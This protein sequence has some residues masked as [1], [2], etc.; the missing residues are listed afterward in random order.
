MF[1]A[2]SSFGQV[3][4]VNEFLNIGVGA[5]AHGMAGSVVA[6]VNDGTAGYWNT[7]ALTDINQPFQL[8]AMHAEWFGGISNYDFFSITKRLNK[9]RHTYGGL[10]FIRLGVD[11]IPNTL[12]LFSADG[13]IDY[14]KITNFSAS[15]YAFLLSYA[16]SLDDDNTF[17]VG[18]NVK[19]IRRVL[20]PFAGAWGFGADLSMK[21]KI[22]QN[23]TV[24]ATARDIT[25]TFNA[26][27][28]NLDEESKEIFRNTNNQ[29]PESSVE[30]TLPRLILGSAYKNSY[31]DFTY[32]VEVDATLSTDGR[33][34]G[35]ISSDKFDFEPSLGIEIGYVNKVF[36]RAGIGNIQKALDQVNPELTK[37]EFQPNIGLG[38]KLGR[39]SVDYALANVGNVSGVLASHIFSVK[40]SF[41]E[42][43][44]PK[45]IE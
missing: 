12:N 6:S 16:T 29:V 44:E 4:F 42:R 19:I 1:L 26:W 5:R 31:K 2:T 3:K 10:S 15:D 24:A 25:T 20:G 14:D 27:S 9:K 37:T 8:N 35:I 18:G 22:N 13:S 43:S 45:V 40:L 11:D 32:L 30:S 28:F 17:S 21:Y 33:Q 41:A 36:L 39:L 23:I 7:A 34:S 38:I